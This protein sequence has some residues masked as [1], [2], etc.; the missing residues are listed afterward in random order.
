MPQ[1]DRAV[2]GRLRATVGDDTFVELIGQFEHDSKRLERTI[3]DACEANDLPAAKKATHELK[4]LAVLFGAK[5]LAGLCSD[6]ETRG[7]L[8]KAA[9]AAA[10]CAEVRAAVAGERQNEQTGAA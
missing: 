4:G 2:L 5:K 10:L 9:K 8:K 7:D 3:V 1:L 6:A